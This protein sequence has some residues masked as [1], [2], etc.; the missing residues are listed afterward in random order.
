MQSRLLP[1][2]AAAACGYLLENADPK[3]IP[4]IHALNFGITQKRL[5]LVHIFGGL[6]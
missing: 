2:T 4:K 3:I 6:Y 1:G 5:F